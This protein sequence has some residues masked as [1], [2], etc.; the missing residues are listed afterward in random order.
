MFDELVQINST[1][2]PYEPLNSKIYS[3]TS[4]LDSRILLSIPFSVENAEN[5]YVGLIDYS[6]MKSLEVAIYSQDSHEEIK[7]S[8]HSNY[9]SFIDE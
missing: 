6:H 9:F 2:S 4:T 5:I 8:R 3:A 1:A 7:V